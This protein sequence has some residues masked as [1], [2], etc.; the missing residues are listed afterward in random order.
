MSEQTVTI[1]R[2]PS[3]VEAFLSLRD[4]LAHTP[5]GGAALVAVALLVFTHDQ[6]VGCQCLTVAV[7]SSRLQQGT[8]GYAGYELMSSDLAL[9]RAQM[10]AS[11]HAP[12]SYF[13][14]A[15]PQNG[16]ALPPEPLTVKVSR[17]PH[18]GD[19]TTGH[20]KVF[21]RSSGADLP[22]PVLMARNDKGIWKADEWSSL[23]LGVKRPHTPSVEL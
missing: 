23:L 4:Q 9:I 21:L 22:R 2:L 5:E 17:N 18:S 10:A 11:S 3:S 20:C 12:H 14:G 19:D 6:T 13:A 7:A 1:P 8:A 16:Y 15:T